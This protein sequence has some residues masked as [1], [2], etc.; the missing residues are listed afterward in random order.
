MEMGK[1]VVGVDGSEAAQQALE[2]AIAEAGLRGVGLI[3]VH[4]WQ[5]PTAVLMSPYAPVLADPNALAETARQTL[6]NS[7]AAA[8]MSGLVSEPEQL[9][10]QGSAASALIGASQ[11]SSLLVVG[12]RG[13][14]GFAGLL[15]GS[16]SQQV[17]HESTI[18]VVIIPPVAGA[19]G[20]QSRKRDA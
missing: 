20:S 3:V 4:A 9:V 19:T 7:L 1:I 6:A 16:V 12:S 8:D 18:P 13:R 17:A 10:L 5:Q 11:D 2:W 15:L 14:G